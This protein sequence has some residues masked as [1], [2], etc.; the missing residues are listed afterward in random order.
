M[1]R[2]LDPAGGADIRGFFAIGRGALFAVMVAA[3]ARAVAPLRGTPAPP[4]SVP[5]FELAGARQIM[6]RWEYNEESIVARGEGVARIAAPDSARLDFFVDG[7]FGS[8][9]ALIFGDRIIAPGGDLVQGMLPS[10]PMLWAA[11]GRLAVPPARD[12]IATV[13]GGVLRADIGREP[14]WRA[15]ISDGRFAMLEHIENDRESES[16]VRSPD[17]SVRY[18]N[19]KARRTL[20]I[21]VTREETVPGFDASIWRP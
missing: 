6:F 3:C 4:S 5:R 13:D 17:G 15:T 20:R 2:R 10:V 11:V 12:T 9:H 21:T 1:S 8:G 18:M 16:I 7:G 19:P 14:R